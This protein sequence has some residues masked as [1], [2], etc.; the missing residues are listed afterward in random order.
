MHVS[1]SEHF[2]Q[3]SGHDS[4]FSP[5]SPIVSSTVF[6]GRYEPLGQLS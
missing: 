6:E 4:H 1:P 5:D 3:L 2:K